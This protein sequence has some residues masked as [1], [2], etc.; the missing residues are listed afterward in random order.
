MTD[1]QNW[2]KTFF[3]GIAIDFWQKAIT[4]EFTKQEIEFFKSIITFK[5]GC[6]IIDVPSGFGRHTLALAK[7]GHHVSAI[8]ISEDYINSLLQ[9]KEKWHL[10]ITAVKAD[11]LKY[12]LQGNF[13]IAMCLGNS[14]SY[15][16]FDKMRRFVKKISNCLNPGGCF[17]INTAMLA[18]SILPNFKQRNWMKVDDILYMNDMRYNT[19]ESIAQVDYTFIREGITE[20][21]SAYNFV[22]TLAEIKRLLHNCGLTKTEVYSDFKRSAYSMGD[23]QAYIFAFK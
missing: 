4:P 8:D 18:E 15:F 7:E 6:C 17:I 22:F 12:K 2:Y 19:N 13:D 10:P 1:Q 16:S 21:K 14:F 20:K 23:R 9:Q 5:K 3:N 11:I